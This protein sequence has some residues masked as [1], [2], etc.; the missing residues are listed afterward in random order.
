MSKPNL[1]QLTVALHSAWSANTGYVDASAWN[2]DNPARGQCVTSSLIVQDFFGGDIVRYAVKA[3]GI[4]ETH[5]ANILEDGTVI[6][7]TRSQ[8]EGEV[9][10]M[11]IPINLAMNNF[12]TVRERCLADE[13]T[14]AL[15]E[16]LRERVD[17]RLL[18]TEKHN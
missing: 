16:I 4:D 13:E 2:N 9:T 5:Y 6:D 14:R 3:R 8:Y 12:R 7:M 11:E 15:Y 1:Q 10:L 17:D 18:S